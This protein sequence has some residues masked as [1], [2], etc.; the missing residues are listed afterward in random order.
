MRLVFE[1]RPDQKTMRESPRQKLFYGHSLALCV[2]MYFFVFVM[3][4][5]IAVS[6]TPALSSVE[7]DSGTLRRY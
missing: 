3:R 5:V 2:W 6:L 7:V 1:A 4:L